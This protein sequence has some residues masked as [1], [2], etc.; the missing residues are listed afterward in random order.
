[1]DE[2]KLD[3]TRAFLSE[4][5]V[6]SYLDHPNI[7]PVYGLGRD[8]DEWFYSMKIVKGTEW[9]KLLASNKSDEAIRIN[10]L[11]DNLRILDTVRNAVRYAH[12]KGIINR[13][14]KPGN[15]MIGKLGEVYVS[16]TG[17]LPWIFMKLNSCRRRNCRA[18][19]R[20]E[21]T[22]CRDFCVHVP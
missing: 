4:A 8:G 15:V 7:V 1:M 9:S 20:A 18:L 16:L 13:D 3:S 21:C 6:T 22:S 11:E 10:Q 19:T 17:A 14:L 2:K 12:D 5:F